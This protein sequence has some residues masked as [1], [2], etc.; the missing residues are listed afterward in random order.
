MGEVRVAILGCSEDMGIKVDFPELDDVV[1]DDEVG[2]KVYD[3]VDGDGEEVG[4]VDTGVVEWLVEC[5]A[6]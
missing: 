4:E 6:D 3:A 5:T 1:D 2:I